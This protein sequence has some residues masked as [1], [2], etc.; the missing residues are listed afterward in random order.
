MPSH[1]FFLITN[2][3]PQQLAPKSHISF[4]YLAY[5]F[6][7]PTSTLILAS[8]LFHLSFSPTIY[9]PSNQH[10]ITIVIII[11]QSPNPVPANMNGTPKKTI[12]WDAE[13]ERDLYGA[14]LVVLGE[15]K[16]QTLGK[17]VELLREVKGVEYTVK[18]ATHRM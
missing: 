16:G 1:L 7:T 11:Q 2:P 10:L 9:K 5:L 15:P 12:K 8:P 3:V 6:P 17:A 14:C 4:V 18:A 13:A